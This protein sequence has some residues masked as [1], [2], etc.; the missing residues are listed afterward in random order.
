MARRKH[1]KFPKLPELQEWD[2]LEANE[3]NPKFCQVIAAYRL[4][5]ESLREN[6]L[7]VALGQERPKVM[8]WSEIARRVGYPKSEGRKLAV[9]GKRLVKKAVRLFKLVD[10]DA[11]YK[12]L[13]DYRRELVLEPEAMAR[14]FA[15]RLDRLDG[16]RLKVFR[17]ELKGLGYR[18][19]AIAKA[20]P[21]DEEAA[22]VYGKD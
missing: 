1:P 20:A 9:Y 7:K 17:A 10:P 18:L 2:L 21:K 19:T 22:L 16:K 15:G 13:E 12:K 11:F 6:S 14:A 8:S 5:V 4:R 3:S